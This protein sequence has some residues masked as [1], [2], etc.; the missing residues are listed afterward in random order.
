MAVTRS[1]QV[2]GGGSD[3]WTD[4]GT[5]VAPTLTRDVLVSNTRS[6]KFDNGSVVYARSADGTNL[7]IKDGNLTNALPWSEAGTT[8]LNS[9]FTGNAASVVSAINYLGSSLSYLVP[10]AP[11]TLA[12]QNLTFAG[13]TFYSGYLSA[14]APN[15]FVTLSPGAASTVI[16]TDATFTATTPGV[17]RF[18][19][20]D[21]GVLELW[22]NGVMVDSFDL[23]AAFVEGQRS[24]SQLWTPFT[25]PA[26]MI[27]ITSVGWY[28]NWPPYQRG[29]ATINVIPAM[30][31]AG[32]NSIQVRHT[33][34]TGGDQASTT[35][36]IFYDTN[37]TRP[38]S[39]VPTIVENTLT[40][41]YRL[42]GVRYYSTLDTF[43]VTSSL[44]AAFD[45]TYHASPLVLTMASCG[46]ANANIA[47]NDAGSG[48]HSSPPVVGEP[49]TFTHS[50]YPISLGSVYTINGRITSTGRDPI[51]SGSGVQ[52]ASANRLICTYGNVATST[53][54]EF[55][56]EGYRLSHFNVQGNNASGVNQW[57]VVPG[58][59]TGNW[60][61]ATTLANGEAQCYNNGLYYPRLNYT[62]G[63]LP[64]TGQTANYSAFAGSQYYVR[65]MITNG[66][67]SNSGTIQLAGW[68]L[69][70]ILDASEGGTP[71]AKVELKIPTVTPAGTWWD[72]G[73][74][75]GHSN[76]C[77]V[78][79][80]G[81]TFTYSTG[82][83]STAGVHYVIVRITLLNNT[84]PL[85]TSV[86][87]T[88]VYS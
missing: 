76:G 86:T 1:S 27:T 5:N 73:L 56:D 83:E 59:P 54:E 87:H 44:S 68:V 13:T 47:W 31:Q 28:N 55:L 88:F 85:L 57:D 11:Q 65:S 64:S 49:F 81:D 9:F 63:Y 3:D 37:A 71:T 43:D 10:A 29:E 4:D 30:L 23:G 36:I 39:G 19:Y 77:R 40:S 38:T 60:N 24:G 46:I 72:L 61:S 82:T 42:S 74:A 18:N 32:E 84:V 79:V 2:G 80:S 34:V 58:A 75:Y 20:A 48:G 41:S 69:A 21:D 33:G 62:A 25:T 52:S 7:A 15:V 17:T 70:T 22:I 51:G 14:G 12:A 8:G 26:G 16:F 6:F 35:H 50:A 45:N 66:N 53:M 67:P 78:S